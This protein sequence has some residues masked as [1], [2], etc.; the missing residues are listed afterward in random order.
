MSKK[1]CAAAIDEA[2]VRL[3]ALPG[4]SSETLIG[5]VGPAV[6]AARPNFAG[7]AVPPIVTVSVVFVAVT[8][9]FPLAGL[10]EAV[11]PV[12]VPSAELSSAS[13]ATCGGTAARLV[14]KVIVSGGL[15]PTVTVS[16]WPAVTAPCVS[17]LFGAVGPGA[18]PNSVIS[19]PGQ[20]V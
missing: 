15:A 2:A 10:T 12:S 11:P 5:L 19:Q 7:V 4:A 13:V 1:S 20:P 18:I 6:V 16:C 3:A 8:V 17:R 9:M 14:P